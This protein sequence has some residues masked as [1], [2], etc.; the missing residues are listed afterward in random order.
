M[1]FLCCLSSLM[2]CSVWELVCNLLGSLFQEEEGK[3]DSDTLDLYQQSLGE[4]LL[5]LA[6]ELQPAVGF[7]LARLESSLATE[8]M[9]PAILCSA[10][11]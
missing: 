4:L 1:R 9:H 7:Q 3:E 11:G 2:L 6:G 5:M 8:T 10:G